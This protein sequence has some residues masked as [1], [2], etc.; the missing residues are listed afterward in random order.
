MIDTI[1]EPICKDISD[2]T[3]LQTQVCMSIANAKYYAFADE[4][5]RLAKLIRARMLSAADAADCLHV[6][7]SYNAL[8][9]EYGVDQIQG[10]MA[11]M[12]G[13]EAAA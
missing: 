7:A 2:W 11:E 3:P 6:A 4:A 12:F 13:L 1:Y 9:A 10:I 5:G 8:Y